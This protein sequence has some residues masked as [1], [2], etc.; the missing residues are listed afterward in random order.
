MTES[1]NVSQY[2]A[3]VSIFEKWHS[4]GLIT[5]EELRVIDTI[6]A[7]KYGI[8]STSI[9]RRNDL[10]YKGNDANIP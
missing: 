7:E 8:N 2:K 10:I 9:Y 3:A 4:I 5:E 1:V 6:T